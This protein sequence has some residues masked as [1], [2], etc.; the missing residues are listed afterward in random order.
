MGKERGGEGGDPQ[1]KCQNL[2]IS[3]IRT[4]EPTADWPEDNGQDVTARSANK[5]AGTGRVHTEEEPWEHT[6]E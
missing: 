6:L 4:G 5:E 3:A 2:G 1:D